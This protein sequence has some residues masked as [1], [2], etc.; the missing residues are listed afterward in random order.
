MGYL[1]CWME[2]G[3]QRNSRNRAC[4]EALRC[5][6]HGNR[7]TAEGKVENPDRELRTACSKY[8]PSGVQNARGLRGLCVCLGMVRQGFL[9][10]ST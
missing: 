4:C 8:T 2:K 1:W 6:L 10:V 7:V 3:K 9:E 5:A